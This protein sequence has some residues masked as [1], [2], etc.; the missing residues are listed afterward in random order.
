MA[1]ATPVGS[2]AMKA[3]DTGGR[4]RSPVPTHGDEDW[5]TTTTLCIETLTIETTAFQ[6]V[7]SG[8]KILNYSDV[9]AQCYRYLVSVLL[10]SSKPFFAVTFSV[11]RDLKQ[12]TCSTF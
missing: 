9:V 3:T 10:K 7:A 12:I 1:S 4:L 6:L 8:I 11:V 2:A 5:V